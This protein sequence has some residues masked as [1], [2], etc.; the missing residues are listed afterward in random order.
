MKKV[1]SDTH[2]ENLKTFTVCYRV[3]LHLF[4]VRFVDCLSHTGEWNAEKKSKLNKGVRIN[5]P[6]QLDTSPHKACSYSLVLIWVQSWNRFL[7]LMQNWNPLMM[8]LSCSDAGRNCLQG[9][10]NNLA[11]YLLRVL[12]GS[13]TKM[14]YISKLRLLTRKKKIQLI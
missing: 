7:P 12:R 5:L 11:L 3:S 14:E 4:I 2:K 1:S 10:D 6:E 13:S 9:I 8:V